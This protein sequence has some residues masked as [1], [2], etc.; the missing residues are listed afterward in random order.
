MIEKQ[1]KAERNGIL[2]TMTVQTP[3]TVDEAVGLH[4]EEDVL[5]LLNRQVSFAAQAWIRKSIDK[6]WTDAEYI[7]AV[8]RWM[9]NKRIHRRKEMAK[10]TGE[11]YQELA[12]ERARGDA[13]EARLQEIEGKLKNLTMVTNAADIGLEK[14][15]KM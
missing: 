6:K 14:R 13:L 8:S 9:P 15:V 11:I 12:E 4:G 5:T 7:E 2:R 1:V 3:E 10:A